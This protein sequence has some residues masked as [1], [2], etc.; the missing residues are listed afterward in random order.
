MATSRS[1]KTT[2]PPAPVAPPAP[3][4]FKVDI[5]PSPQAGQALSLRQ[6]ATSLRVVDRESHGDAKEFVRGAKALRR[7]IVEHWTP[8]KRSVDDLKRSMLALELKDLSPVDEVIR[9]VEPLV[10][11]WEDQENRRVRAEEDRLRLVARE[12]AEADRKRQL[13]DQEQEA[14]RLEADSPALSHREQVFVEAITTVVGV[15]GHATLAAEWAGYKNPEKAGSDLILREKIRTAIERKEAAI[16]IR[17][18]NEALRQQPVVVQAPKVESQ[19]AKVAG[20]STRKYY[21]CEIEDREAFY[22]AVMSGRISL[23]YVLPNAPELNTAA[24]D[25]KEK[26]EAAFPGCRLVVTSTIAGR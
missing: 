6:Q 20:A 13:E 10:T 16:A 4:T 11:G 7:V 5:S 18:Q 12:Q 3:Q 26:F 17:E 19:I 25:L 2:P 1:A 24:T 21:K 22:A 23:Q 15:M 8:I 14:L 9:I